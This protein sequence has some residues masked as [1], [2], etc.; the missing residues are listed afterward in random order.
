M[1]MKKILAG[2]LAAAS[3]LTVSATAFALEGGDTANIVKPGEKEYSIDSGMLSVELDLEI[4]AKFQAF[5]NPYGASVEIK[6][7]TTTL[8][9]TKNDADVISYAYEFVNNTKDFG[10][11]IDADAITTVAGE[12]K[13]VK[14]T[15]LTGT[16]ATDKEANVALVAS[17][18]LAKIAKYGFSGTGTTAIPAASA[19]MTNAADGA[20]VLD[21]T[22]TANTTTGIAAGETKQAGWAHVKA[23]D[24]TNK[25][26]GK[27]YAAIV[28]KLSENSTTPLEWTDDDAFSVALVLKFNPGPAS[29]T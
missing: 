16:A 20:L 9:A 28:G 4:P 19:K 1:T 18:D 8:D 12:L 21:S 22:V 17:Y 3:M 13:T 23:Y 25:T 10:V 14:A 5:L 27:T 2:V 6:E 11:S 29:L 26:P 24:D 15:A 7:K